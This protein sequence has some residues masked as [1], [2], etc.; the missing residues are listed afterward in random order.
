[1]E[2][3]CAADAQGQQAI[4]ASVEILDQRLGPVGR[5]RGRLAGGLSLDHQADAEPAFVATALTDQIE[6]TRL[7][8][9]QAERRAGHQHGG[10][11]EQ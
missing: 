3:A 8:Y 4:V 2:P 1:V 7:E 5:R 9:A 6:I 10:Q 11:W